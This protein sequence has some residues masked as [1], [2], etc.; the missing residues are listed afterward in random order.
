ML[1]YKFKQ[2][3]IEKV[4]QT[5]L[6][7]NLHKAR[8]PFMYSAVNQHML[9]GRLAEYTT[10]YS[11]I[12]HQE[13]LLI[14][15]KVFTIRFW[16]LMSDSFLHLLLIVSRIFLHSGGGGTG[17][18]AIALRKSS[19]CSFISLS[20]AIRYSDTYDVGNFVC[21]LINSAPFEHRPVRREYG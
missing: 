6:A 18:G 5:P 12:L 9:T 8:Q 16:I 14:C 10:R 17:L 13:R 4:D 1:G 2:D 11:E 7:G 20:V 3:I 21:K 19:A 15:G